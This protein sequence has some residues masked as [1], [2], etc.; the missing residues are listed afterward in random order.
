MDFDSLEDQIS[1][2]MGSYEPARVD[3][4]IIKAYNIVMGGTLLNSSHI[5]TSSSAQTP[6]GNDAEDSG[7]ATGGSGA[8]GS[9]TATATGP[10]RNGRISAIHPQYAKTFVKISKIYNSLLPS[11]MF[12]DV[13]TSPKSDI[14]LFQRF[15]Q[16]LKELELNFGMS[17]FSKYFNKISD[18]LFQVKDDSELTFVDTFWTGLTDAILGFYNPRTGKMINQ[19][20]KK[21][22]VARRNVSAK[23]ATAGAAGATSESNAPDLF[24]F[25]NNILDD[26]AM[27]LQLHKRL[28]MI[29][30]DATSRSLNGYYT[31]PTSPGSSGFP[32]NLGTADDELLVNNFTPNAGDGVPYNNNSNN[33]GAM[34]NGT[35]NTGSN[36]SNPGGNYNYSN[37]KKRR[38]LGSLT[39]DES[40]MDDLLKFTT[41]NK[42]Q[43][44]SGPF[45][46]MM[47]DFRFPSNSGPSGGPGPKDGEKM[48]ASPSGND[49]DNEPNQMEKDAATAVANVST[50]NTQ[51]PSN[52]N[53]TNN[54][55]ATNSTNT[56]TNNI[57][58]A[59]GDANCN[60]SAAATADAAGGINSAPNTVQ[61]MNTADTDGGASNANTAQSNS[62][63]SLLASVEGNLSDQ[64]SKAGNNNNTALQQQQPGSVPADLM[65]ITPESSG[66]I[67][68]GPTAASITMS[69]HTIDSA[70][71][72]SAM[73]GGAFSA[74]ATSGRMSGRMTQNIMS[75][76]PGMDMLLQELHRKYDTLL[77]EK[78]KRIQSLESEL[79]A[80][81]QETLWLRK[82]LIEDMGH[83][84]SAL[85][86][87]R[88]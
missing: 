52:N 30:Q 55:N 2:G 32:F 24:N 59:T 18:T 48:G 20:R 6:R 11:G 50:Q 80:Q 19:G 83:I 25:A 73:T 77:M 38:S 53:S 31:Q 16:V 72:A 40:A 88:R 4:F 5:T 29:P 78:D 45:N 79:E 8:S 14:E 37:H 3:I 34:G 82:M 49:N 69:A 12:G 1:P 63:P 84:R 17:P 70:S 43:R 66:N 65:Q 42:K 76:S 7:P 27:S 22:T 67:G 87:A 36:G 26:P 62:G 13:S 44:L 61:S 21:N 74:P 10:R 28:Q 23:L 71:S 41:L 60:T 54:P 75:P 35:G 15:Q 9:G 58:T 85:Q 57:N 68:T 47:D 33:A 81:R 56:N 64:N 51:I 86:N 46:S 39:L